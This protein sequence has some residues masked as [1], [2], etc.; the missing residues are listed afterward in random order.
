MT[1][2]LD[3]YQALKHTPKC[4][5]GICFGFALRA[6]EAGLIEE[7]AQF[8][9]RNDYVDSKPVATLV[10][11]IDL[12]RKKVSE[13]ARDTTESPLELNE[14][15]R[16]LLNILSF[17]D[18]LNLYQNVRNW[19]FLVGQKKLIQSHFEAMSTIAS[20]DAILARGGLVTLYS[21]AL[22]KDEAEII[23]YL[24]ELEHELK[25][26]CIDN[27]AP[28]GFL[29]ESE[30]HAVTLIYTPNVGWSYRDINQDP[31][32]VEANDDPL[33]HANNLSELAE[34]ISMGFNFSTYEEINAY[35]A[36]NI[37]LVLTK[38]DPRC[39]LLKDILTAFKHTHIVTE[40]L[41]SRRANGINLLWLAAY[42]G[43][44]SLVKELAG[45]GAEIN[46]VDS[47][48]DT[49]LLVALKNQYSEIASYL[50][51]I[52]ANVNLANNNGIT[53]LHMAVIKEYIKISKYLIQAG[54]DLFLTTK[55]GNTPLSL[56]AKIDLAIVKSLI[57]YFVEIKTAAALNLTAT[58]YK[59]TL[60]HLE[61]HNGYLEVVQG[62]I[63]SGADVNVQDCNG[64]TPL[65]IA[66]FRN[67]LVIVKHLIEAGA[68]LNLVSI[69]GA[70]PL[71]VAAEKGN[72]D[73][74]KAL[75]DAGAD[76]RKP[77]TVSADK[78]AKLAETKP[79]HIQA[80]IASLPRKTST[81]NTVVVTPYEIATI[82]G[83][84][85]VA[86]EIA[87]RGRQL[88]LNAQLPNLSLFQLNNT[89]S[90][91]SSK[92]RKQPELDVKQLKLG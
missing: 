38:K 31:L 32:D 61:T 3:L 28:I 29:L 49:P 21:E 8:D 72:I 80:R 65:F 63:Q 36:F 15:E 24:T 68:N 45:Q 22:I 11:E 5:G 43:H 16:M 2:P 81:A 74:V 30:D 39:N 44:L 75:L 60:L 6:L 17:Y 1:T 57:K 25:R 37:K 55:K 90:N 19:C 92:K 66:A 23:T 71:Y 64:I 67:H 89:Q 27:K 4:S 52:K 26:A 7:L 77:C 18:S 91:K 12:V 41:A 34:V 13:Q 48:G 86:S 85:D 69:N 40:E 47:D 14:Q 20:S 78:L 76:S 73:V 33:D 62:L 42:F 53:P 84:T 82:M 9:Y 88:R 35:T 56:A 51:S 46:L 70:T 79:Q 58:E 59:S 10:N 83:H 50:I 54:A 87:K